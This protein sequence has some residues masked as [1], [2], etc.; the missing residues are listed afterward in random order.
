MA[1][2]TYQ[3]YNDAYFKTHEQRMQQSIALAEKEFTTLASRIEQL[4]GKLA[5]YERAIATGFKTTSGKGG[6]TEAQVTQRLKMQD[7]QRLQY[8][9]ARQKV[10]SEAE[11]SFDISRFNVPDIRQAMEADLRAGRSV[12]VTLDRAIQNVGGKG[13]GKDQLQKAVLAKA[14]IAAM[15]NAATAQ[16]KTFSGAALRTQTAGGMG[17]D[18]N[19][20]SLSDEKLKQRQIQPRLDQIDKD[21]FQVDSTGKVIFFDNDGNVVASAAEGQPR[22][23]IDIPGLTAMTAKDRTKYAKERDELQKRLERLEDDMAERYGED[24]D[25]GKIIDRG[26]EIYSQQ[27]APLSS[28]QRAQLR[29]QKQ[30]A[31]LTE[32]GKINF[33]AYNSVG[34]TDPRI[35]GL[36]AED[37][38]AGD[39]VIKAARIAVEAKRQGRDTDVHQ[40]LKDFIADDTQRQEALGIAIHYVQQNPGEV[41]STQDSALKIPKLKRGK[42]DAV[43]ALDEAAKEAGAPVTGPEIVDGLSKFSIDMSGLDDLFSSRMARPPKGTKDEY[44][45]QIEL[46]KSMVL[47]ERQEGDR[48]LGITGRETDESIQ[49][50]FDK[51]MDMRPPS[52]A[53]ILRQHAESVGGARRFMEQY[54]QLK[55]KYSGKTVGITQPGAVVIGPEEKPTGKLPIDVKETKQLVEPKVVTSQMMLDEIKPITPATMDFTRTGK[56]LEELV[57]GVT[58]VDPVAAPKKEGLKLP[59]IEFPTG[60]EIGRSKT[61]YYQIDGGTLENPDIGTYRISDGKKMTGDYQFKTAAEKKRDAFYKEYK[62]KFEEK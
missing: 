25:L 56:S 34:S 27:Y 49:K 55:V 10:R 13:A 48:T 15:K 58:G 43:A 26:R 36:F 11:D 18:E 57:K 22:F 12:S 5:D 2:P 40:M 6:V 20:L 42:T 47:E 28:A 52:Q 9:K 32:R 46:Q 54:D 23:R 30:E 51:L 41:G 39:P 61:Y 8:N 19:A 17:V 60:V 4:E 24:V 50:R 31:G 21:Y 29:R 62:K 3:L 1:E 45:E 37:A 14:L 53:A 59:G 7:S 44:N 35:A 16:G 33:A 38:D